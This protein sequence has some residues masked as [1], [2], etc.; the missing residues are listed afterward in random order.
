[1]H[2]AV[3]ANHN[4]ERGWWNTANPARSSMDGEYTYIKR[5]F[6]RNRALLSRWLSWLLELT[7][8]GDSSVPVPLFFRDNLRAKNPFFSAVGVRCCEVNPLCSDS[9]MMVN[10]YCS[11]RVASCHLR[12]AAAAAITMVQPPQSEQD[13][14]SIRRPGFST[15]LGLRKRKSGRGRR[16]QQH[17][18]GDRIRIGLQ[19]TSSRTP[20]PMQHGIMGTSRPSPR[21]RRRLRSDLKI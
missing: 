3:H 12:A 6:E 14:V 20:R 17:E 15:R 13:G 18:R 1:M 19:E 5:P 4:H 9:D 11:L 10:G 21:R 16:R 7:L 2:A 8:T